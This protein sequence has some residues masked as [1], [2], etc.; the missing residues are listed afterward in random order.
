MN[1]PM[2]REQAHFWRDAELGGLELLRATYV[3]HSFSRHSHEGYALGVIESGVE[4]FAYRGA[5]HHAGARRI[6]ICHPGE[7]H[8]GYAGTPEG[9]R[10]RMFYPEAAL[11]QRALGEL[12]DSAGAI[13]F[14][15][16]AVIDDPPLALELFRLHQVLE[17]DASLLERE[18]RLLW[19]LAQLVRRHAER[20]PVPAHLGQENE[21]LR[22][23]V[24]FL[25]GH[26]AEPLSLA[27]L[28]A[29]AGLRPLTLLR[30]FQ[31]RYGLPPHAYLV[32]LRV[33]RAKALLGAGL[34]IAAV[35][36]DTGFTDQSHLHRHFKRLTGVTPG[37]YALACRAGNK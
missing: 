15:P 23:V 20:R 19:T 9:W 34:P 6:V 17:R 29:V 31:R 33:A 12:E 14:F 21:A 25:H 16:Q 3:T 37:Q 26:L 13:P 1:N 35:A 18:S 28:A 7:V 30:L 22:R 4:S 5:T 8:T 10:Y 24:E 11:L 2:P 36:V 32:Q 27:Q